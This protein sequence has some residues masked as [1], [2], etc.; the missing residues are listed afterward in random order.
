MFLSDISTYFG[1]KK[2]ETFSKTFSLD[3]YCLYLRDT[4]E[5][6]PDLTI[7]YQKRIYDVNNLYLNKVTTDL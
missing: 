2:S 7:N 6:I 3:H 4:I 1:T 5:T